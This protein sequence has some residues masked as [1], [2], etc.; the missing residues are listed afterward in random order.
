[1]VITVGFFRSCRTEMTW[2]TRWLS[3]WR[4]LT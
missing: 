4:R 1:V 2:N 3:G